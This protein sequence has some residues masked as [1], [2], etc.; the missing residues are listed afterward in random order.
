MT[1]LLKPRCTAVFP[2]AFYCLFVTIILI[3]GSALA[4]SRSAMG[5][6][7][8]E[9]SVSFTTIDVPGAAL[10]YLGGI[11]S[12]GD[13]VGSYETALNQPDHAFV[14][15]DGQFTLFDYPGATYTRAWGINDAGLIVGEAEIDGFYVV[16]YLYDGTT[17]ITL[18]DGTNSDTV[19][20]GINNI[21]AV[22]GG[23][24]TPFATKG[25]EMRRNSF[26]NVTPPGTYV[27]TYAT[28][29]N[30]LGEVV[31]WT[32]YD[33]FS[34]A[35]GKFRTIDFPGAIVTE[36]LGLNDGGVVV[37]WYEIGP[38][39]YGFAFDVGRYRSFQYPGSLYTFAYGINLSGQSVGGYS[40]DG[41]TYHG[42]VTS[43]ITLDSFQRPD[44]CTIDSN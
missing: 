15:K 36:A 44:C 2:S 25:F 33:G 17:F 39:V 40:P 12:K 31:G 22:V 32:D 35:R 8:T 30:S 3:G 1:W 29:I 37:G 34:F 4:Q 24:G 41:K 20:W 16:G 38:S 9:T 42:F 6:R 21:G 19:A 43:P 23:T 13:M 26:R 18:K 28:G 10:T 14:Y 27:Y 11:N 5:S 7:A